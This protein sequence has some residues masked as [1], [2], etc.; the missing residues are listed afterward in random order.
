MP[1]ERC[2]AGAEGTGTIPVQKPGFID[3]LAART[4]GGTFCPSP[5]GS[6]RVRETHRDVAEVTADIRR[7]INTADG[8]PR[9][10]PEGCQ[11]RFEP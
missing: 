11:I 2:L 1:H 6:R 9:K 8:S 7:V 4:T 10:L 3:Q 5:G